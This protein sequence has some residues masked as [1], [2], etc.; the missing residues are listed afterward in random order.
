MAPAVTGRPASA[1]NCCGR[2]RRSIN[3]RLQKP[4]VNC[5]SAMSART[6]LGWFLGVALALVIPSTA[7]CANS[8]SN[9]ASRGVQILQLPDRLRVEINGRLFTEYFFT[10][11]PRPFCYPLIGPG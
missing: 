4:S 9:A 6:A 3:G 11:V 5:H 10:N 2:F 8:A 1:P 7:D